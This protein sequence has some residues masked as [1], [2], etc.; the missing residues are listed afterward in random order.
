[1]A[2]LELEDNLHDGCLYQVQFGPRQE[3]TLEIYTYGFLVHVR[4]GG[5]FNYA[6]VE[7]FFNSIQRPPFPNACLDQ[8]LLLSYDQTVLSKPLNL[9]FIM[10]MEY[11]GSIKI[12]CKNITLS[13]QKR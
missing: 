4:F 9:N 11:S 1:M 7:K 2:Q 13:R 5:I 8:I 3:A 12:H 10:Q 6:E